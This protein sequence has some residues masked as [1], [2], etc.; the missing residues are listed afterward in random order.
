MVFDCAEGMASLL[1][2]APSARRG[3]RRRRP[4][5]GPVRV[6][7]PAPEPAGTSPA[8]LRIPVPL[9][10]TGSRPLPPFPPPLRI[11][12]RASPLTTGR[13][14]YVSGF[15]RAASKGAG[16]PQTREICG[17]GAENCGSYRIG[18]ARRS[19][20]DGRSCGFS[21]PPR[22]PDGPEPAP[23]RAAAAWRGGRWRAPRTSDDRGP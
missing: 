5:A 20:P 17:I 10:T 21:R 4:P 12:G 23:A 7:L 14:Q 16:T 3:R 6:L 2:N 11:A 8:R 18:R 13:A 9:S 22:W 15:G 19:S 1:T